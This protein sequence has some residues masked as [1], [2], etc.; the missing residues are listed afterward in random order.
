MSYTGEYFDEYLDRRETNCFKWDGIGEKFGVKHPEE[1]IPMWIADMDFRSP[2]EVIDTIVERAQT[3]AYG[4]TIK[5][6]EFF[7]AIIQW[8][9]RHYHWQIEKD[10]IV[11]TPGVIP[12]FYMAI[13]QFTKPGEG[14]IV[15]TPV[16]YPFMEGVEN[17][18]RKLVLNPLIE[19]DGYWTMDFEDLERKAQ[20]PTNKLMIISNPHNP[21][22]RAW[23]A[24]ELEKLVDIC[25]K[26]HV[27]VVSDE[28]HADL[29]MDGHEHHALCAVSEKAR[30]FAITQYAPSKTFNLAGLQTSY[31]VIPDAQ[32][33]EAFLRQQTANRL[34]AMNWFG[35]AALVTAYTKCDDYVTA[36]CDYVSANMDYMVHFLKERLPELKMTKPEATYMVWVDFRGTGMSTEEIEKFILEKA[37]IATDMGSWFRDGGEGYLRFNLACPRSILEKALLQLEKALRA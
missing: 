18:D 5:K 35:A 8:V 15:Q 2:R 37:H 27:I 31:A 14:V 3:L 10:W 16:Y 29:M 32:L 11:F 36:L 26:N 30:K 28:I 25:E 13:Q 7:D 6:Q 20:D 9:D 33:R 12:G 24:A 23:T 21:V 17:N 22:G 34:G 4:Y 1:I 19:K